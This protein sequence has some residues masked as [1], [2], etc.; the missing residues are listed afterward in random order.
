MEKQSECNESIVIVVNKLNKETFP[1][2]ESVTGGG[3]KPDWKRFFS[4]FLLL[5]AFSSF[6]G[7]EKKLKK[8]LR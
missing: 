7:G 2:V 6:E 1:L 4:S 3:F 8:K 5:Q